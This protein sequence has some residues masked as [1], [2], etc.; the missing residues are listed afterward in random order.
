ME[1][2]PWTKNELDK[3]VNIFSR[4]ETYAIPAEEIIKAMEKIGYPIVDHRYEVETEYGTWVESC[5]F[6]CG[7]CGETVIDMDDHLVFYEKCPHCNQ[8][9]D[10]NGWD[11][12]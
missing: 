12:C 1:C 3:F 9:I 6:S 11:N 2:T 8:P 10:W 5:W 4:A 7:N